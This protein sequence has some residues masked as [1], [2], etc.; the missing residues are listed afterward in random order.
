[1]SAALPLWLKI[2]QFFARGRKVVAERFAWDRIAAEMV[3]CYEWLLG[4]R[5]GRRR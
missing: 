3:A 2:L 5:V 1:M 4:G